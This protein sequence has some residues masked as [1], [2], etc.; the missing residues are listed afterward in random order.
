MNDLIRQVKHNC[1]ISDAKS[2][3]YYSLCGLLMRLRELYLMEHSMRPWDRAANEDITAWIQIRESLWE[4]IENEEL[5]PITIDGKSYDPF[6]VNRLNACLSSS[7]F[8]YGSGHGILQK[9]SFFIAELDD[10]REFLD[11]RI[12]HAGKELCRDLSASPAMLQG[13]CIYIRRDIL[14]AFIWDRFQVLRGRQHKGYLKEMFSGF[15]ISETDDNSEGLFYK[16]ENMT[17]D[18][19]YIFAL[20]EIGEA[21]ED[22]CADDW[23]GFLQGSCD[24]YCELYARGVKDLLA[25][26]SE[27]G[28]L[29]AMI[30][31]K[32]KVLLSVYI[33][34][35]N[36]IRKEIFPEIITAYQQF[37]ETDDWGIIENVRVAGYQK[38]KAM[39]TAILELWNTSGTKEGLADKIKK[40]I[41]DKLT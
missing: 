9:P 26:T 11:Y 14:R 38:A 3:G 22:D 36:G 16:I 8:V 35:L 5:H 17:Q 31:E 39:R 25:D 20:H 10:M 19:T 40:Y 15:G 37:I 33:A 21:F 28:P 13:R 29:F 2:W 32:N 6:D 4:D 12:Y 24:K 30:K 1:N 27:K 7:G 23:H 34:L 18:I 41:K